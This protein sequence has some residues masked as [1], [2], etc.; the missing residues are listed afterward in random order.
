M[1]DLEPKLDGFEKRETYAENGIKYT[2]H[3]RHSITIIQEQGRQISIKDIIPNH[4]DCN[5]RCHPVNAKIGLKACKAAKSS[6]KISS[7][8]S[9]CWKTTAL[10]GMKFAVDVNNSST[11]SLRS[12]WRR[13]FYSHIF[14]MLRLWIF[15]KALDTVVYK[16]AQ[17]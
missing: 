7:S 16:M 14:L 13:G 12:C 3:S 9:V 2:L 1:Q 10:D 15:R 17:L 4:V 8:F 5:I 6:I 11:K